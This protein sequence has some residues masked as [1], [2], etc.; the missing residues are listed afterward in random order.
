MSP[1]FRPATDLADEFPKLSWVVNDGS[2]PLIQCIE[3]FRSQRT[4]QG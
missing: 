1:F 2:S 3:S 4:Q